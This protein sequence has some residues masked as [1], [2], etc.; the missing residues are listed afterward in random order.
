MA[1]REKCVRRLCCLT[2]H[3]ET[4]EALERS[5]WKDGGPDERMPEPEHRSRFER[6]TLCTLLTAFFRMQIREEE[7]WK[8]RQTGVEKRREGKEINCIRVIHNDLCTHISSRIPPL[9]TVVDITFVA[10]EKCIFLSLL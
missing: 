6:H 4:N 9:H 1:Q 7:S 5:K 10:R 3:R 2:E 8:H